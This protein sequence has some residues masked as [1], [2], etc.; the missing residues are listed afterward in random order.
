MYTGRWL[1]AAL[2]ASRPINKETHIEWVRLRTES[3][4]LHQLPLAQVKVTKPRNQT[5]R[6]K[7]STLLS[8]A[9]G[10]RITSRVTYCMYHVLYETLYDRVIDAERRAADRWP[11]CF[12]KYHDK[13]LNERL[14]GRIDLINQTRLSFSLLLLR[15]WCILLPILQHQYQSHFS[16]SSLSRKVTC[17]IVNLLRGFLLQYV[18][19][20]SCAV[21]VQRSFPLLKFNMSFPRVEEAEIEKRENGCLFFSLWLV[22]LR[23]NEKWGSET[24]G[25]DS[26]VHSTV[27]VELTE[28]IRTEEKCGQ[29]WKSVAIQYEH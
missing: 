16:D 28:Y 12:I 1:N 15:G 7:G 8:Q 3:A 21:F 26:T 22:A 6:V 13:Q 5:F 23:Q 9:I 24:E 14:S 27:N 11:L 29:T 18:C 10:S 2:L 20:G 19:A 25:S 17:F 4:F